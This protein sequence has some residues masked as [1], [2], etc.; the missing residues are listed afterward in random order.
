MTVGMTTGLYIR[1]GVLV[2]QFVLLGDAYSKLAGQ[3]HI[4]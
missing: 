4:P 1:T 2:L 3:Q